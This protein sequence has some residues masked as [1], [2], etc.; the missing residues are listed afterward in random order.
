MAVFTGEDLAG[1]FAAPLPMVWAPPGRRDQHAR[2]LAAQARPGKHVGDPV[3]VVVATTATRGRRRRGRDRRVRPEAGRGRPEA[4]LEDGSPLVWEQF[5]T[6]QTH[7]WAV[8]GGDIDAALAEADVVVE[9]RFV[10]HRTVG[11][12][13]RAARLDRRAPRR[14]ADALL[15]DADPAHRA[16]RPV[17]DA[18]HPR[19]Q[20]ARGRP[21]RGRRLRRQAPG[22]RRGG[23]RARARQAAGAAGQ[24]DRDA[25]GAHDDSATTAATR[26]PT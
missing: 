19:G 9:Q 13:D 14:Q 6:N 1:D 17:G 21:R 15:D 18:R 2:A 23:A 26:S 11:R 22:L 24:V 12:A 20:A 4:A 10:N 8:A 16:L 5:G 3:A 7:E 25:L